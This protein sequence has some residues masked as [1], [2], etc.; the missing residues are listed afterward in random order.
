[1]RRRD[2]LTLVGGLAAAPAPLW[3]RA[4]HAQ[5]SRVRRIGWLGG[6]TADDSQSKARVAAFRDG[7]RKLGWVDGRNVR[8]E[9]RWAEGDAT[10]LQPLAVDLIRSAPDVILASANSPLDALR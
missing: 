3:P 4:A 9:Y 7:L 1:M 5:D 6:N 2:F 8:I 10:R